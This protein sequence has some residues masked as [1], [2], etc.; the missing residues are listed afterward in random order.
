MDH[1]GLVKTVDRFGE[2]VVIGML[3]IDSRLWFSE[4]IW[5]LHKPDEANRLP[6]EL[7]LFLGNSLAERERE[8]HLFLKFDGLPEGLAILV[9]AHRGCVVRALVSR[10]AKRYGTQPLLLRWPYCFTL[11]FAD[12]RHWVCGIVRDENRIAH[13]GNS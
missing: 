3:V 5:R 9:S 1:L 6:V 7:G 10:C 11:P 13:I 4:L 2:S 12:H 8:F